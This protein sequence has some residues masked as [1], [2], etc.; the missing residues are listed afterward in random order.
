LALALKP[1]FLA[2]ALRVNPLASVL[3]PLA[4][5]LALTLLALLTYEQGHMCI[6]CHKKLQL[7][8]IEMLPP[9]SLPSPVAGV[10][11][12]ERLTRPRRACSA[13]EQ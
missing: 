5:T 7:Y 10:T 9:P 3:P 4:L 1:K 11:F 2:L 6:L 13:K 8:V 12:S